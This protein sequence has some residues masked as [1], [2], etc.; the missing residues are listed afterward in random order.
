M[1][2][3]KTDESILECV[4]T[5]KGYCEGFCGGCK[6][7]LFD[8]DDECVLSSLPEDWNVDALP[9]KQ[10][11]EL[12]REMRENISGLDGNEAAGN[13]ITALTMAIEALEG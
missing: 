13:K 1:T 10:A 6:G 8:T 2:M 9:K 3:T 5:L 7:C 11:V 4:K 12:L